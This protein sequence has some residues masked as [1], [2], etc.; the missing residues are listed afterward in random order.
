[1]TKLA[2]RHCVCSWQNVQR[3]FVAF[4]SFAAFVA[5]TTGLRSAEEFPF[6]LREGFIWVRANVAESSEPLHFLLD[7]GAEVSTLNAETAKR[8]K[9]KGGKPVRVA[10]VTS[11]ATG[12][13]P[14]RIEGKVGDVALPREFL[15]TD[16]CALQD[17]C[18]CRVDGLLGADFLKKRVVQIDF[19]AREIR[20]L[21]STPDSTNGERVSIRFRKDLILVPV[22]VDG[23]EQ[24]MRL[25]TGCAS[26]LEWVSPSTKK[27]RG[28]R[29]SIG[30]SAARIP[31][32]HTTI[33]LGKWQ[34][35]DVRTGL[36]ASPLFASEDGLLGMGVLSRFGQVTIDTTAKTVIFAYPR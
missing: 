8:L 23:N 36:H 30:L 1:M 15:V 29:I 32:A 19:A 13:W 14:Q 5:G 28:T 35:A 25:D 21:D 6:E 20:L 33:G 26:A 10:G 3:T 27:A 9:L 17:S 34:F 7:T 11:K 2:A 12:Y 18:Q 22:T 16:L 24:W 4:L 31:T